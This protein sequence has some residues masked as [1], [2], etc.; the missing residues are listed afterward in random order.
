MRGLEFRLQGTRRTGLSFSCRVQCAKGIACLR[1]A[2]S[3]LPGPNLPS[4]QITSAS[5]NPQNPKPQ[6][7]LRRISRTQVASL[8]QAWKFGPNISNHRFRASRFTRLSVFGFRPRQLRGCR[9]LAHSRSR[10]MCTRP[11]LNPAKPLRDPFS[12]RD[13]RLRPGVPG[14]MIA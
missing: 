11:D 10:G 14:N 9:V 1:S 4:N 6:L 13:P 8:A 7:E 3:S 5:P 12:P 2:E